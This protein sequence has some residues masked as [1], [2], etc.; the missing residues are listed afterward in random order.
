LF[1]KY[2]PD[3]WWWSLVFLLKMLLLNLSFVM[4]I[5]PVAQYMW[6]FSVNILYSGLVALFLPYRHRIVS[7]FDL[8][9]GVSIMYCSSVLVSFSYHQGDANDTDTLATIIVGLS[10]CPLFLC[11]GFMAAARMTAAVSEEWKGKVMSEIG[12]AVSGLQGVLD[13]SPEEQMFFLMTLSQWDR[14]YLTQVKSFAMIEI[15]GNRGAR[16]SSKEFAKGVRKYEGVR[17]SSPNACYE[18]NNG[19]TDSKADENMLQIN[20]LQAEINTLQGQLSAAHSKQGAISPRFEV[21][22]D[23]ANFQQPRVAPRITAVSRALPSAPTGRRK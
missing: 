16:L 18:S 11:V 14:W 4:F 21:A 10:F 15:F 20:T 2:R 13:L 22:A 23:G 5:A 19:S 8:L 3:V 9:S 6:M 7:A 12:E 1:I 17:V